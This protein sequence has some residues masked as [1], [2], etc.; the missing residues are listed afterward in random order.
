MKST[1]SIKNMFWL[2]LTLLR[3]PSRVNYQVERAQI[4]PTTRCN[5][6]CTMCG[7]SNWDREKGDMSID[8]FKRAIDQ[9][10]YLRFLNFQGIGEP[11]INPNFLEMVE[12][13]TS[14]GINVG[15]NTNATL[16]T[17]D[18][19]E[20]LVSPNLGWVSISFDG[21]T[22]ETFEK[23]RSGAKFEEVI[24]NIRGLV[25]ANKMSGKNV[26]RIR[27]AV[28]AMK[29]NMEEL[30]EIVRLAGSLGVKKVDINHLAYD[31]TGKNYFNVSES[32]GDQS[33][34]KG[35]VE[36]VERIFSE[37][38]KIGKKSGIDVNLPGLKPVGGSCRCLWPWISTYIA[39]DG[40]VTPCCDLPDPRDINFGNIFKESFSEIWNS[41]KLCE[42]RSRLASNNPPDICKSCP[43]FTGISLGIR[44]FWKVWY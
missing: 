25:E 5:L 18:I 36:H 29:E 7:N 15:F 1:K 43:M 44:R 10:P 39:Y 11:L 32:L 42:F 41:P 24:E 17:K 14:K 34:L 20:K 38:T 33:L 31:Y 23:I 3:H 12:Y 4:E 9:L 28:V 40:Y 30:P 27:F 8:D 21:A 6:K 35:D 13:A 2:S 26:P 37:C 19:S 16:L 22:A